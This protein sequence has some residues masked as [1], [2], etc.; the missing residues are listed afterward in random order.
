MM[1]D[2]ESIS[3]LT[4]SYFAQW[5]GVFGNNLLT[6][7]ESFRNKF[8]RLRFGSAGQVL[9]GPRIW[10]EGFCEAYLVLSKEQPGSVLNDLFANGYRSDLTCDHYRIPQFKEVSVGIRV[11]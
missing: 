5:C 1:E 2:R 8:G 11:W 10:L 6:K 3:I 4:F 7:C 9:D